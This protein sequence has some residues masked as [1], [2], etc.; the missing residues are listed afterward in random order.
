MSQFTWESGSMSAASSWLQPDPNNPVEPGTGDSVIFDSG[1]TLTGTVTP[2]DAVLSGDYDLQGNIQS[3]FE[4]EMDD[5]TLTIEAGATLSGAGVEVLGGT[6]DQKDGDVSAGSTGVE[7]DEGGTYKIEGGTLTST[8]DLFIGATDDSFFTLDGGIVSVKLLLFDAGTFELD[9]GELDVGTGNEFIGEAAGETAKFTQKG[10]THAITGQLAIGFPGTGSYDLQAGDLSSSAEFIGQNG[11][12]WFTQEGGSHTVSDRIVLG[13]DQTGG[14][15]PPGTGTYT[16][17]GDG[18][19][20]VQT[21]FIGSD[22]NCIGRFNFNIG[23]GDTATLEISGAGGFPGLI[24]GGQGTGT[25]TQEDGD[26]STTVAVGFRVGGIGTYNFNG[27]TLSS[28]DEKIGAAGTGTFIHHD[29][30]NTVT[31]TGLIVGSANTATGVYQLHA[32]TLTATSETIGDQGKGTFT[33]TGGSNTVTTGDLIVGNAGSSGNGTYLLHTG[34]LQVSAGGLTVGAQ[35]NSTGVFDFNTTAGDDATLVVTSGLVVVG[36]GGTGTFTQGAGELDADIVLGS[37]SGSEG[38]YTLES[39][40][41]LSQG[42]GE[43]IGDVG[44]GTFTQ[45]D[46]SNEIDNG[47][48]LIGNN[49]GDGTYTLGGTASLAITGGEFDIAVGGGSTGKFNFNTA[50]GDAATLTIDTKVIEVGVHGTATFTMGGGDLN[51]KLVVGGQVGSHGTVVLKDGNLTAAGQTVGNDGTG[52]FTQKGGTDKITGGGDLILGA[53]AAGGGFYTLTNGS[54]S[55]GGEL[56]GYAGAGHFNQTGGTN[57]ITGA[58]SILELGDQSGAVG[59]YS[60]ANAILKANQET[61]GDAG[62]GTFTQKSGSNTITGA[63]LKLDIGAQTGG[64]GIYTLQAGVLK[65]GQEIV[66]D[67]GTGRLTQTGGTNTSSGTAAKLDI[68]AQAASHGTYALNKGTITAVQEIVGDAGTGRFTQAN[69]ANTIAGSGSKL[70]IAAQAASHGSY[71]LD[72]G[73][74]KTTQEIVG[75][76][77]T[78]AFTQKGGTNTIIGTL[79]EGAKAHSLGIYALTKGSLTATTA[80][81]GNA[82]TGQINQSGGVDTV[83]GVLTLGKTNGGIG[84]YNLT[85]G[86]LTVATIAGHD[87][88]ITLGAGAGSI[89][90]LSVSHGSVVTP[91][92]IIG[93]SGA[94]HVTSGT[95]GVIRVAQSITIHSGSTLDS[96]SGEVIAGL[97]V[98]ATPGTIGV[99][100]NGSLTGAGTVTGALDVKT[101]GIVEAH[102]GV[103]TLA[104]AVSGTG[105]LLIDDAATLDLGGSDANAVKF[106]GGDGILKLEH[107]GTMTG[108]ITNL[109]AGDIIDLVATKATQ[110]SVH[111]GVMTV[112]VLGGGTLV[113]Q[114]SGAFAANAFTIETDG[115]AGRNLVFGPRPPAPH[116]TGGLD[117]FDQAGSPGADHFTFTEIAQSAGAAYATITGFDAASD[118]FDLPVAVRS[119]GAAHGMLSSAA[120]DGDLAAALNV[121]HLAAHQAVVFTADAGDLAGNTFLVVD[122]NG[123]AGYQAGAGFVFRLDHPHHLHALAV[124]DFT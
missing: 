60:L 119:I 35:A 78:G 6:I 120:F 81:V 122:A 124:A 1:G 30:T 33:Q 17:G 4:S 34:S 65:G 112:K 104:G 19:L 29:G 42:G 93:T 95:G 14:A 23:A 87:D 49:G 54:L 83:N 18:D 45:N 76:A 16:L 123:Q 63:S 15:Q 109:Q 116:H 91:K 62:T 88:Y 89:G 46:G 11:K 79:N 50:G 84:V 56:V 86:K 12:G 100:T 75:D 55:D 52:R 25:F 13:I 85:G 98:V 73:A 102:G 97:G 74:L 41:L 22:P 21:I 32:G 24:V 92:L 72:A 106:E 38:T 64:V 9:D 37:Q 113:F 26:V 105:V 48:L 20:D 61:I 40:T 36:D 82:G 28:T 31:G 58:L 90:R 43:T 69:G 121:G 67:A 27:G 51:A 115:H 103:L 118:T 59:S 111:A 101:H 117:A 99:G 47:N 44:T 57:T 77:G 66:G 96:T 107:P 108:K 10:G 110:V 2:S 53:F 94:G 5:G 39:G 8:N 114:V 80:I 71:E 3:V 7:V 70:D 68:G